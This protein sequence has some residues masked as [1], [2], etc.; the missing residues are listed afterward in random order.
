[1]KDDEKKVKKKKVQPPRQ[2][3]APH[4]SLQ[5]LSS[6]WMALFTVVKIALGAA[7]T[8][9]IIC[10]M[11]LMVFAGTL[12][13][14]LQGDVIPLAEG[15]DLEDFGLE[16]KST[17]FY[18]DSD[19]NIK[20]L[21]VLHSA[22]N[23]EW[24]SLDEI[25]EDLVNATIAIEDK[26]FYEHQGVDWVTTIK[27]CAGMFLGG[28]DAGGSTITQQLVK[29][30]TGENSFTV[31][32]KVLEWFRAASVEKRYD[33]DVILELYLNRIYLGQGCYGVR[34]AAE[35]YFGKEIE[36][37]TTAECASL[38]SITNNPSLFDPY[39]KEFNYKHGNQEPQVLSG[40]ER[41][42][43]RQVDTLW[44]M[45]NQG[46]I[47]EPQYQ[48]ALTQEMVFKNGIA[49]ED[50]MASCAD[51]ECGYRNIVATFTKEGEAYYCPQ[52]GTLT[53]IDLSASQKVYSWFVDTVY[54]DVAKMLAEKDGVEWNELTKKTYKEYIS[55]AGLN[56]YTTLDMDV[57]N[58]VDKIYTNLDEIP[59]TRS[60]QQLESAIVIVD[61][62]TGFIV[63]MAGAVGE[64]TVHDAWSRATDSRLQ[65]GSSI[66]PLTVYAPAFELGLMTPASVVRDLPLYVKPTAFPLND[67]R[68]Y[69]NS[70]TI[71]SAVTYSVNAAAVSVLEE[72][73]PQYSFNFAKER[74]GLSGLVEE[75]PG[76]N[77]QT[78]TDIGY[79]PLGLGAQT[80]GITVRDMA[81]AFATFANDGVYRE[82][83][84]FTKVYDSE[85][86]LILDNTQDTR[87]ILSKK[88][89][90]YM[91]YCLLNAVNSGTGTAAQISGQNVA[92]KTGTTGDNKDRWFCG[93]TKHYTAAVWCGY[94]IPEEIHLTGSTKNPAARLFKKVMAPIHEGLPRESLYDSSKM[95]T[96]DVCLDSGLKATDA[97]RADVRHSMSGLSS[98]FQNRVQ[99]AKVYK[100][101]RIKDTC[102]VHVMVSYCTNGVANEYC[103][104]FADAG[105]I[106]LTERALVKMTQEQ[107]DD[108]LDAKKYKLLPEYL[109]DE[110]VYL[111]KKN[112]SDGSWKGF[113]NNINKNVDAPYKVC[114]EHTAQSWNQYQGSLVPETTESDVLDELW[115][116][117]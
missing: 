14:Y 69:S 65:T 20:E 24:A 25:P 11:C 35:V 38:I 34:S 15:M 4:W 8:V 83:L 33:K 85:G 100:E 21:Q 50:R 105:V 106:T 18:N 36:M 81:C 39:A 107:I 115:P 70:R 79:A 66:K 104:K 96:V 57:Q 91:N 77:G 62:D 80:K 43:L 30:L 72:I 82:G 113:E 44:E 26:R 9:A 49:P 54:E 94:N 55:Q 114:T 71:Y 117:N 63:A 99:Q 88:S 3:W 7:A 73:T 2:E 109:M 47:S 103:K 86:N 98:G 31:Q 101:D 13:D 110:Y 64:K 74:F 75:Y 29:N 32:R 19:G 76:W 56:I 41:N 46:L 27:A 116:W 22:I 93:Y 16:L 10:I 48:E 6:A 97:C 84:T 60:A 58:Q 45:R 87:Q 59:T 68:K 95:V 1:M 52:C 53:E 42:R 40:A 61:N 28:G 78:L 92:G 23:R 37:L 12:G 51:P 67:N 89:V 111:V 102:D 5:I 17:M 108:L 112:G 90:D